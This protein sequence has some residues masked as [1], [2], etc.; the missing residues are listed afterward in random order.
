RPIAA[1][2]FTLGSTFHLVHNSYTTTVN[3]TPHTPHTMPPEPRYEGTSIAGF[4]HFA[5]TSRALVP[6]W[7]VP[8]RRTA[9]RHPVHSIS[10]AGKWID[11]PKAPLVCRRL[12]LASCA[13]GTPS[14]EGSLLVLK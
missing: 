14:E 12:A 5:L 2:F 11:L 9:G 7:C 13:M 10:T 3:H 8:L 4:P 1:F 6:W